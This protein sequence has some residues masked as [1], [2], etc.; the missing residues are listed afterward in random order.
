[1]S[2]RILLW[3]LGVCG[4]RDF[5]SFVIQH[6]PVLSFPETA[7]ASQSLPT[8]NASP[9]PRQANESELSLT[10]IPARD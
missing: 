8:T 9:G 7:N 2:R 1:M 5:L 4:R 3:N 10:E 6:A